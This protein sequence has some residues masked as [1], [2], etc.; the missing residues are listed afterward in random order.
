MLLHLTIRNVVIID[1]ASIDL[2]EGLHVFTG[3]TGAGK[4]ILI[5][6]LLLTLGERASADIVRTDAQEAEVSA[7]FS[8]EGM[9][10][11]QERLREAG[12]EAG[13]ELLMRRLITQSGRSR[14]YIND[15]PVT[16]SLLREI[17]QQLVEIS[18]QHAHQHLMQPRHHLDL[19]DTFGGLFPLRE[20]LASLY[21][22]ARAERKELERLGGDAASR[23][24][25]EEYLLYQLDE[26]SEAPLDVEETKL[27]DERR[28]LLQME[29]M[30]EGAEE[31]EALLYS[32]QRSILEQLGRLSSRLGAWSELSKDLEAARQGLGEAQAAI[33]DA[34]RSLRGFLSHAEA[35]PRRLKEIEEQLSLLRDLKRKHNVASLELLLKKR[36]QYQQ[37]ILDLRAQDKRRGELE[38]ICAVRDE[39]LYQEALKLSARR[40]EIAKS[41]SLAVE[42]ELATLGMKKARFVAHFR[43]IRHEEEAAS[44]EQSFSEEALSLEESE[45]AESAVGKRPIVGASGLDDI[46]FF[47]SSNPGEQPRP[48]HRIASG[49]ELSR[50]MLALKQILTEREPAPTCVFDEVD[51]GMGGFTATIIGEKIKRIASKRQ[52]LCITH[53]PQIACFA[54]YHYQ[55]QKLERDGRTLSTLSKL[56]ED[57]RDREL[58]RMLGGI[59]MTDESLAHARRLIE[60]AQ[61]SAASVDIDASL[62]RARSTKHA[63]PAAPVVSSVSSEA[64]QKTAK[65]RRPS[66]ATS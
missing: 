42:T 52:V 38:K 65:K 23:A 48:L 30:L 5:D 46:Q 20:K 64:S 34:A 31:A 3:E 29:K 7:L 11:V 43:K 18:G 6:S 49:G 2:A 28:Y 50:I 21:Q 59:E 63:A 53:L 16:V 17:G 32:G 24:R 12:L 47:L 13:D 39:E 57:E 61:K 8:V 25:R 41:L 44:E 14:A 60:Q 55:I 33:D 62:A 40:Q 9:P 66:K 4:S 56:S 15:R 19:L 54:R 27:E 1:E 37:E 35:D 45:V 26:L 22:K 10:K 51:S 36:D 58:A